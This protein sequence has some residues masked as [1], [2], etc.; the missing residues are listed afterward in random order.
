M[1]A[2]ALAVQVLQQCLARARPLDQPLGERLPLAGGDEAGHEVEGEQPLL[3]VVLGEEHAAGAL[4]GVAALLVHQQPGRADPLERRDQPRVRGADGA[5]LGDGLV[6][7]GRRVVG[8]QDRRDRLRD[9]RVHRRVRRAPGLGEEHVD[10]GLEVAVA[11]GALALTGRGAAAGEGLEGQLLDDGAVAGLVQV[12]GEVLEHEPHGPRR[13]HEVAAGDVDEVALEAGARRPPARGAQQLGAVLRHR[14]ALDVR[15]HPV[16]HERPGETGD[17]HHAVDA[18]AGVADAHLDGGLVR[19]RAHVEI[20]H[21][22]VGHRPRGE[23]VGDQGVVV[24]GVAQRG[25]GTGGR[26]AVPRQRAGAG[27]AGVLALPERRARREREQDR[28]PRRAVLH[29][30]DR[31][32]AVGDV[33][34]HLGAADLLLEGEHLVL[35]AHPLVA[36]RRGDALGGAVDQGDAARPDHAETVGVGDVRE[37]PAQPHEIGAQVGEVRRR[38]GVRLDD[39]GLELRGERLAVQGLQLVEQLRDARH[40]RP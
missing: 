5:V 38:L 36:G 18:R 10:D 28:Q 25:R 15:A 26:P 20:D 1:Q 14:P 9:R 34:V 4:L 35:V 39:R 23:Q 16:A 11:V 30:R 7:G 31:G 29:H 21:A 12:V 3:V 33:D 8:E 40:R 24:G 13:R 27:V 32:V 19:R 17:Q 22:R 37:H 2:G 6:V